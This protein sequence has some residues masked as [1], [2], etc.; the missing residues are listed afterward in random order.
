MAKENPILRAAQEKGL[1]D[2]RNLFFVADVIA[3]NGNS[4]RAWVFLNETKLYL[5]ELVFPADLGEKIE[6]LELRDAKLLKAS[7]FVLAP[8]AELICGGTNYLFKNFNLP[9][10]FVAA[11]SEACK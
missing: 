10:Q 3:S 9:K 6:E 5:Y 2:A 8:K 7:A 1:V 4:G 11:L